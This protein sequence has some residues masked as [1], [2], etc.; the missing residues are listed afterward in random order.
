MKDPFTAAEMHTVHINPTG[1]KSYTVLTNL[2]YSQCS[3]AQKQIKS[4]S[5]M[6]IWRPV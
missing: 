3:K 4:K 1:I 6:H 2:K 5:N